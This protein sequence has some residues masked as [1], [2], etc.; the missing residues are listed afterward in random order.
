MAVWLGQRC[1][2]RS[3][4]PFLS[5]CL[6]LLCL[7]LSVSVS[8]CASLSLCLYVIYNTYIFI[9]IYIYICVA[10]SD[11][12]LYKIILLVFAQG[13]VSVCKTSCSAPYL[14]M[15]LH[16]CAYICAQCIVHMCGDPKIQV[17]NVLIVVE[18]QIRL[19][20]IISSAIVAIVECK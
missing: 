14:W 16:A 15:Q 8:L 20:Q 2:Q 10:V 11:H 3:L 5:V 6:S 7:S 19:G 4:S 18:T 12:G 9:Y 1:A 17:R 13:A